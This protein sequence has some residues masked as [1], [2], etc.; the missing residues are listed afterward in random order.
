MADISE[1][2]VGEA[3]SYLEDYV[4]KLERCLAMLNDED[5]WWRPNEASNSVGNLLLHLAGSTRMWIVGGA[6]NTPRPRDRDSEFAARGDLSGTEILARLKATVADC[7]EVL[8][9]LDTGELLQRRQVGKYDVTVLGAIFHA[10][11]HFSMHTG[12]I[13]MLTKM[14]TGKAL[15]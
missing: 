2:F 12:Q 9:H 13:I 11:E 1:A 7:D 10:V 5:V 8:Q 4:K 15:G 3:R 6:G 14:R